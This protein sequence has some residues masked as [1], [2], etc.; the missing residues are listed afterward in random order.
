MQVASVLNATLPMEIQYTQ[1]EKGL[2]QKNDYRT[3]WKRQ[4]GG[5]MGKKRKG[6]RRKMGNVERMEKRK[7]GERRTWRNM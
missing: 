4:R 1:N 2:R 7:G 5:K 6:K 3:K